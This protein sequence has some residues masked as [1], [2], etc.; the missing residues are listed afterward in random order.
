M[1]DDS[2]PEEM[3]RFHDGLDAIYRDFTEKVAQDRGLSSEALDRV[4]RGRLWS[5]ADAV[6]LGLVDA[7]WG[8]RRDWRKSV[9]VSG[10]RPKRR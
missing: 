3:R 1:L 5:G 9:V 6:R 10:C 8:W 7:L 2:T 4:A